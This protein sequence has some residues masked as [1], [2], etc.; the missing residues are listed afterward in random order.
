[1]A[2]PTTKEEALLQLRLTW[3]AFVVSVV[4][5]VY[6]GETM[7]ASFS[8]LGFNNARKILGVLSILDFFY[9]LWA[10]RKFFRPAV[11]L[12]RKQPED[13]RAVKR[14][15]FGWT[16]LVTISESEILLGFT[17]WM[18]NKSLMES[19]PIFVLGSLMLLSLWPRQVWSDAAQ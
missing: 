5:Y 9:F 3:F 16:V 17:L 11:E 1:M 4:L 7:A 18:G 19:L 8:W 12:I 13:V 14:W 2:A 10:W 15:I 6:I